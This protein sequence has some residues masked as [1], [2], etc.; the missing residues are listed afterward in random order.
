[1]PT[2]EPDKDT[3]HTPLQLIKCDHPDP[4]TAQKFET[5]LSDL[6]S[7]CYELSPIMDKNARIHMF[8]CLASLQRQYEKLI[9]R[10]DP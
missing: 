3:H 7:A 2:P 6:E 10:A 4:R 9:R 5:A 8:W 1:M